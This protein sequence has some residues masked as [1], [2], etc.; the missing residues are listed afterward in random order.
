MPTSYGI[1]FN[2]VCR[3]NLDGWVS[4]FVAVFTMGKEKEKKT[5]KL[6]YIIIYEHRQ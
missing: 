6:R 3:I 2:R 5:Q 1:L 4:S